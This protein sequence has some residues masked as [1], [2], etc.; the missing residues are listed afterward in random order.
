MFEFATEEK[1]Y[2]IRRRKKAVQ[3]E[4]GPKHFYLYKNSFSPFS[5]KISMKKKGGIR[6]HGYYQL[7]VWVIKF[8]NTGAP[9]LTGTSKFRWSQYHVVTKE[10]QSLSNSRSL[11]LRTEKKPLEILARNAVLRKGIISSL[12]ESRIW[13]LFSWPF[14]HSTLRQVHP[15]VT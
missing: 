4:I 5:F 15:S 3:I 12:K 9:A 11:Q 13:A 14:N 10:L 1:S 8:N 6:K 7:N 2:R